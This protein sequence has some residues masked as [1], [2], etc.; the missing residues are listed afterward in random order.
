MKIAQARRDLAMESMAPRSATAPEASP[1]VAALAVGRY[2]AAA[3]QMTAASASSLAP[4]ID[5]VA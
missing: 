1:A 5:R 4:R 3:T 2:R